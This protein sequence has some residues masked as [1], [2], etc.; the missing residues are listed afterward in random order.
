MKMNV[1][2]IGIV[3]LKKSLMTNELEVIVKL[4]LSFETQ[5]SEINVHRY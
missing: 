2:C 5:A 4:F 1:I 3:I